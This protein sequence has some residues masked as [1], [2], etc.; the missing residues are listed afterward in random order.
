MTKTTTKAYA[1]R[2]LP[3]NR[4]HR[5]D[6][7]P[8]QVFNINAISIN[9]LVRKFRIGKR[10]ASQIIIARKKKPINRPNETL[11]IKGISFRD[12]E[13][14][15]RCGI[16]QDDIRFAIIDVQPSEK[17]IFSHK[18]FA[19]KVSFSNPG[20]RPLALLSVKVLWQGEPFIVE[21]EITSQENSAGYINVTFD[22]NQTLPTGPVTFLTDLFDKQ[23]VQ[24][25]FKVTCVVLPSNPLS[26]YIS[27]TSYYVTGTYSA[28][29]YYDSASNTY[30]TYIRLSIYNG[31]ST[32]VNMS[33]NVGWQF[34]DGGVGGTLKESGTHTWS[35]A[36]S[37]PAYGSWSGTLI[38]TS[39]SGSGI[40]NT[41]DKKED[42]TIKIS[43][44]TSGG[45]NISDT[46]TARVMLAF[47]ADIIRIAG[48]TFI[49]QE[50]TDLYD[51][52]DVTQSI[53]EAR[54]FT[55]RGI[56]RYHIDDADA[57]SY[58]YM[59]SADECH[60]LF[61]D[62]SA[63]SGGS[64]IDVFIAHDFV[65]VGFDGLAG[66][67]PGPTSH[68]GRKSG[69][70][71]DKTGY[72]DAT[73]TKRLSVDYLGMLIAHE[74]GHYLGLSHVSDSSNLM[75]ANSGT[76]DTNLTYDQYRDMLDHGWVYVF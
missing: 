18:P 56:G 63:D 22:K 32:T 28:R 20:K 11:A 51:A 33:R 5:S 46:I 39:P 69:V 27:P 44:S 6:S 72:V 50:Y 16:G 30:K 57:G 31:N 9:D 59:N 49:G 67:V 4:Y 48:D 13:R 14:L 64:Y 53:Y 52:V 3:I 29:G 15:R 7:I 45:T 47:G 36:I 23:G 41:Y 65:G 54:D 74:L 1:E 19:L 2:V 21:K 37:V 62:W 68:S 61:A 24:S 55:L 10:A 43:M 17:Y 35:T 70:V 12:F 34:W 40:Y 25:S 60:D 76:Y 8:Y 38:F 73:G 42:M 71:V 26:L 58:K 75:L 66:D